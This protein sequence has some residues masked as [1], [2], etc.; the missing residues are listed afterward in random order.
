MTVKDLIVLTADKDTEF[1]I[2]ALLN[3]HLAVGIRQIQYD[4]F[5]HPGHD[6]GCRPRAHT[7]LRAFAKSYSFAL[8]I[9]D[10]EGCGRDDHSRLEIEREAE[11]A[12]ASSGWKGRSSVIVIDP[13]LEAWVWSDSPHV[14]TVLGWTAP[15]ADLHTWLQAHNF[16]LLP[17]RKPV[18]PK[19]AM[20]ATLR[21]MRK[22]PSA[23]L[24]QQLASQVSFT[25]CTDDAFLKLLTTL[26]RWFASPPP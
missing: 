9:F 8:V 21:A 2:R 18:R 11:D 12:L 3:R 23:A 17:N 1:S 19:E 16:A 14:P 24:F 25:R 20:L 10:R 26:R 22:P 15:A 5:V 4:L 7:F 13:E 6:S